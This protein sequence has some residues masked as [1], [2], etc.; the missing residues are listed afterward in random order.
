MRRPWRKTRTSVGGALSC[1]ITRNWRGVPLETHEIVVDLASSTR[2]DKG[3]EA[4]CWLVERNYEKG[5]KVRDAEWDQVTI[6]RNKFHDDWNYEIISS[7][8]RNLR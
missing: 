5:C 1:H 2:T 4:H 6:K 3:L 8:R 7:H